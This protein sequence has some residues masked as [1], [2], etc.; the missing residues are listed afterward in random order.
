ML[1]HLNIE[2]W[3]IPGDGSCRF[4]QED[5]KRLASA[6]VGDIP[7]LRCVCLPNG[8]SSELYELPGRPVDD[9]IT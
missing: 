1:D 7:K 9:M 5:C 3:S 8:V 6:W 2:C 4:S